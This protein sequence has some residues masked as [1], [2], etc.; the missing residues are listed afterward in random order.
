VAVEGAR[1]AD[2]ERLCTMAGLGCGTRPINECIQ[3]DRLPATVG[4]P[5]PGLPR[6]RLNRSNTQNPSPLDP[7]TASRTAPL[8]GQTLRRST[9]WQEAELPTG[10]PTDGAPESEGQRPCPAVG[11][12]TGTRTDLPAHRRIGGGS[13]GHEGGSW[14]GADRTVVPPDSVRSLR[15]SARLVC[16][17]AS[18]SNMN[19][20]TSCGQRQAAAIL[21]AHSRAASREGTSTT[22]M[23]PSSS[24]VSA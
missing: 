9:A 20:R 22:A 13:G 17:Q 4:S 23:P 18:G 1:G 10:S 11:H 15:I 6:E 16:G 5:G 12:P 24:L 3:H 19:S 8:R 7:R 2:V 21:A 14:A